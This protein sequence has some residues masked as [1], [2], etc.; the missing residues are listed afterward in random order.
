MLYDPRHGH[1]TLPHFLAWCEAQP[2][3]GF[4]NWGSSSICAC[5]Q[6]AKAIGEEAWSTRR[7]GF[8]AKANMLALGAHSPASEPHLSGGVWTFGQ[9]TKR[10]RAYLESNAQ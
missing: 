5:G 2:E 1:A 3:N 9:L 7:E 8:W 6:Y 10:V 4:Y